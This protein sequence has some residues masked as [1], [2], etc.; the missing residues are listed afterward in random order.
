VGQ[1]ARRSYFTLVNNFPVAIDV[2]AVPNPGKSPAA[3]GGNWAAMYLAQPRNAAEWPLR[4][5]AATAGEVDN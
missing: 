5:T 1:L 4:R 3:V 2:D